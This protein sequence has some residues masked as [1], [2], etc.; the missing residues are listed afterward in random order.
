VRFLIDEM[1]GPAVARHLT[2]LGHDARHVRDLGLSGRTDGEV[3][4]RATAEDRVVVTENAA[5]FVALLDAATSAGSAP[6]L[7]RCSRRGTHA[8]GR[9]A[10]AGGRRV[11]VVRARVG[12]R[13]GLRHGSGARRDVR[14]VGAAA[15]G[16]RVR[17]VAEPGAHLANLEHIWTVTD[18][19]GNPVGGPWRFSTAA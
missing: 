14:P 15:G 2:D 11:V 7:S 10:P 1:F 13:G 12:V 9:G 8:P 17:D 19:A 5:D 3:F 4:D 18:L 16:G 6:P